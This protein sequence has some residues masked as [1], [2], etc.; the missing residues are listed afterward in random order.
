MKWD[1]TPASRK[2]GLGGADGKVYVY[3]V[4]E[5]LVT[6]RDAEWSD[7]Q[8]TMQGLTARGESNF[9]GMG[10]TAPPPM[11]RKYSTR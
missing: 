10:M 4:A 6:P 11:E 1:R 8:K 7:M 5:K 2:V 3:D 9:L